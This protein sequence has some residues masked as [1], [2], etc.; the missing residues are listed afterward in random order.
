MAVKKFVVEY[1]ENEYKLSD[2]KPYEVDLLKRVIEICWEARRKGNHPFGCLLADAGGHIL[3]E[4]GN[5]EVTLGGDCTAHA[6]ALLMRKA[7][8]KYTKEEMANF[9][10][11]N[12]GEPCAMC[13]GAIY[14]GNLGRLVMIGRESE[15]KK[16]TGDDLRNPTLDLTCRVVFARGQKKI[17]VLGP[18]LE[19]EGEF[20]KCHENYWFP[21][22]KQ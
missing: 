2:L 6:E 15:L 8:R 5:E 16:V 12:C 4:Q 18:F 14:W 22:K 10:M 11:Y 3:M 21:S 9:T 1:E 7:S 13:A 17:E 20:M 19:M